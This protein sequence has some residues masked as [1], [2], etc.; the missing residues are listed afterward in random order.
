MDLKKDFRPKNLICRNVYIYVYLWFVFMKEKN[1]RSLEYISTS[2]LTRPWTQ[3][4]HIKLLWL[5]LREKP[6]NTR[7][8][9]Q[10][11]FLHCSAKILDIYVL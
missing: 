7:I 5:N 9:R 10:R 4:S 8:V 6:H 1:R 2:I 3:S 11:P